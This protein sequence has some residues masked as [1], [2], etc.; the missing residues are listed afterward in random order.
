ME[1]RAYEEGRK[2]SNWEWVTSIMHDCLCFI[3]SKWCLSI[4]A[5]KLIHST[6]NRTE[7]T[8]SWCVFFHWNVQRYSREVIKRD[9]LYIYY[10]YHFMYSLWIHFQYSSSMLPF[11]EKYRS[12]ISFTYISAYCRLCSRREI[13]YYFMYIFS[14]SFSRNSKYPFKFSV[15][16]NYFDITIT[17]LRNRFSIRIWFW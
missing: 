15:S 4:N 10:A 1:T 16:R 6:S 11:F 17:L 7:S 5:S 14:I 8:R 9:A 2:K 3:M 12:Q 13:K